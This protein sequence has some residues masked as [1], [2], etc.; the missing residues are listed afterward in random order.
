MVEIG[1]WKAV[2]KLAWT[3]VDRI[4]EGAVYDVLRHNG[5]Q[6][7]PEIYT[8]GLLVEDLEGYRLEFII[9][10]NCGESVASFFED[11]EIPLSLHEKVALV[12]QQ[13]TSCLAQARS[14]GVLH[15]DIS[16]GNIAVTHSIKDKGYVAKVIDWGHAKV[17]DS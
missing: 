12:V 1:R 4:P 5:V 10:E 7:V 6:G 15:R 16:K 8:R 9:M 11:S 2:L 17:V 3:P 14:A 13:V